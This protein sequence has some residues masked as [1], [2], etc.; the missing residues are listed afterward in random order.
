MNDQADDLR[1]LA[2]A[3]GRPKPIPIGGRPIVIALTGGDA[4]VGTTTTAIEMATQLTQ[5]G[6]R[7]LLLAGTR[8]SDDLGDRSADD[9]DRW[10]D[11][12][13]GSGLRTEVAVVDIG[14]Y[15]GPTGRR[16]CREA[17]LIVLVTTTETTAVLGTFAAMKTLVQSPEDEKSVSRGQARLGPSLYLRVTRAPTARDAET[18]HY[19]LQRAG[20]RFLGVE[21]ETDMSLPLKDHELFSQPSY[22]SSFHI[23]RPSDDGVQSYETEGFAQSR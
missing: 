13:A 14:N 12:F 4:G 6:K 9:G 11:R 10:V 17:D 3:Y 21:L 16:I 2:K 8:W 1:R 20:R 5:A 7:T 19:R 15:L 23:A 18:V 22:I